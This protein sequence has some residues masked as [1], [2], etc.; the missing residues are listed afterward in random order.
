MVVVPKKYHLYKKYDL[1]IS[2]TNP[3][4]ETVDERMC[5]ECYKCSCCMIAIFQILKFCTLIWILIRILLG[6]DQTEPRYIWIAV[7]VL[8]CTD[9]GI[10]MISL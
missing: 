3:N 9:L 5:S 7:I 1:T 2:N 8:Q 4:D 6:L 10:M